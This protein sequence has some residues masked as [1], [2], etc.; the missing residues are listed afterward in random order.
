MNGGSGGGGG[1]DGSVLQALAAAV[2]LDPRRVLLRHLRQLEAERQAELAI[3][4]RMLDCLPVELVRRIVYISDALQRLDEFCNV[5]WGPD[6]L[7]A[8]LTA[9]SLISRA[10]RDAAALTPCCVAL[11]VLPLLR[12]NRL[13]SCL[14]WLVRCRLADVSLAS[15]GLADS[16]LAALAAALGQH[17][18]DVR[19]STPLLVLVAERAGQVLDAGML[20]AFCKLQALHLT[21]Y[22]AA[23]LSALPPSATEVALHL[24]GRTY[25]RQQPQHPP[26]PP[27]LLPA[28]EGPLRLLFSPPSHRLKLLTAKGRLSGAAGHEGMQVEAEAA[29]LFAAAAAVRLEVHTLCLRVPARPPQQGRRWLAALLAPAWALQRWAGA[30]WRRQQLSWR[31]SST[32]ADGSGA[33]YQP[34][35][36]G[37][38]SAEVALESGIRPQEACSGSGMIPSSNT[39]QQK[40]QKRESQHQQRELVAA[41]L[42]CFERSGCTSATLTAT[43]VQLAPVEP[44]QVAEEDPGPAGSA[45]TAAA[46]TEL[47]AT[48]AAA[49][50]VAAE[51]AM[52]EPAAAGSSS[53]EA[54]AIM[55]PAVASSEQPPPLVEPPKLRYAELRR[56]LVAQSRRR[57]VLTVVLHDDLL[58][59]MDEGSAAL[60]ADSELFR[61]VL[62]RRSAAGSV[63]S[64]PLLC[65]LSGLEARIR[66]PVR[67]AL[68]A[69]LGLC[70]LGWG[71][72]YV[73]FL[74]TEPLAWVVRGMLLCVALLVAGALRRRARE[75]RPV[76]VGRALHTAGRRL[77]LACF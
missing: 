2:D 42:G 20:A 10:H 13:G 29:H 18:P 14:A 51:V 39:Q 1:A 61:L 31:C 69:C 19:F 32:A 26:R 54:L 58:A 12:S 50:A 45:P 60:G 3:F 47:R 71:L 75:G 66:T 46:G 23:E 5:P 52:P 65:D 37:E 44:E 77:R 30:A 49:A 34:L 59:E 55:M 38:S 57:Q 73:L 22:A 72:F 63:D 25:G 53:E 17:A 74:A 43:C 70:V 11:P 7:S 40:Q 62:C 9:V 35:M 8:K 33:S 67:H 68:R 41:L 28:P 64:R 76:G 16:T 6:Q 21:Q 27:Y 48:A 15:T 56:L 24:P 36:A 4:D